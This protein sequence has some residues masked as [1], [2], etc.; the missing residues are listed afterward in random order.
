MITII[1][2]QNLFGDLSPRGMD[3]VFT[4]WEM[5]V[6][7]GAEA[8]C[9]PVVIAASAEEIN[10]RLDPKHVVV[11][12]QVE[13]NES[14]FG[15]IYFAFPNEMVIEIIGDVLM[16]PDSA[17]EEKAR[18]GLSP[19]DI[20]TFQEMANLLCGSWNR[21]FQDLERNLRISQSVEDLI[22]SPSVGSK[23]ALVDRVP[24]GRV[25]WVDTKVVA[26]DKTYDTMIV[27]PFNVALAVTEEF[28]ATTDPRA[29][30][31]G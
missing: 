21:V 14:G 24:D 18:S 17:K 4:D 25:A 27:L 5:L 15:H 7:F 9:E 10:Q 2:L 22:V 28:Y 1:K 26:G 30:R 11:E 20:E 6:G 12:T 8:T 31:T 3:Q 19:N 23:S 16:I 29:A 13:K